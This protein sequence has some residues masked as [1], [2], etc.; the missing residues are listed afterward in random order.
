MNRLCIVLLLAA[1]SCDSETK[2]EAERKEAEA[3]AIAAEN[4]AP[5]PPKKPATPS[6]FEATVD[7]T[8]SGALERK[9]TGPV[10]IC[11]ATFID[12]KLQGGNYGVRN[13]D[14]EF[15]ILAATNEELAAPTVLLN[16]KGEGRMSFVRR[17]GQ[18]SV[19]IDIER[20]ATIDAE[21]KNI[22]GPQTVRVTGSVTCGPNYRVE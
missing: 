20:G 12:G 13:D 10:G 16:T 19:T 6:R 2:A 3:E 7:L 21:L 17:P 1:T 5:P 9:F 11:G 15:Q 8:F 22:V 14:L 18:G 4:A